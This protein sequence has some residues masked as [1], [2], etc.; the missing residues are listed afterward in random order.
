LEVSEMSIS[1]LNA[2]CR[3]FDLV[4]VELGRVQGNEV[5]W[6]VDYNNRRRYYTAPEIQD[7]LSA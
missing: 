7:K 5:Y 1:I 4:F 6:F 3:K 2:F